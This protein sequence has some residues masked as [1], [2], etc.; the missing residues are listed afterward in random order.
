MKTNR[1]SQ[2]AATAGTF[3]LL[4]ASSALLTLTATRATAQAAPQAAPA[5]AP[6]PQAAAAPGQA[7][8]VCGNL[9]ACYETADFAAAITNFR[10]SVSG[11]LKVMDV[12]VRFENKTAQ[13]L[14]LG[15]TDGSAMALDDQGNRFILNGYAGPNAVRGIGRVQG[16]NI[17]PKFQLQP[18]AVGDALFELVWGKNG[19]EGVNYSLDLTLR[20]ATPLEANQYSLGGEFPI[21]FRGLSSA[22]F[23]NG[24][25]PQTIGAGGTTGVVTAGSA[26]APAAGGAVAAAGAAT[27]GGL[28]GGAPSALAGGA[29]G[30]LAPC[31]PG[32]SGGVSNAASTVSNTAGSLGGQQAQQTITSGATQATTALAAVSSLKSM[33]GRK[34]A[35]QPAAAAAAGQPC[36]PATAGAALTGASP[37]GQPAAGL[38]GQ[39][40]A[41]LAA[42]QPAAATALA[43]G[44]TPAAATTNNAV[45]RRAVVPGTPAQTAARPAGA[46][47][48]KPVVATA[49]PAAAPA[50]K[51]GVAP[52]KPVVKKPVTNP[53]ATTT[54]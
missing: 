7:A 16:N 19:V 31:P 13:R 38:V 37:A 47:V 11:G 17:D 39:P 42:G 22:M 4:L 10:M 24:A 6:A 5:A 53:P 48:A 23:P 32:S 21:E 30:G 40:A 25:A 45:V 50:A 43:P 35:A 27:A 29:V 8:G 41:A 14:V 1:Y 36:A 34:K 2:V 20:E 52:A 26:Y 15:Y 49:K 12:T 28:V 18:G 54:K 46:A 44:A 51:P 33:F 3:V 9:P